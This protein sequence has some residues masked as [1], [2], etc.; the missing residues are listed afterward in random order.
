MH[1]LKRNE[2]QTEMLD[3][4]EPAK[5]V[6]S[7]LQ[8]KIQALLDYCQ[9][10]DWS[11]YDPYDGLNSRIFQAT[12]LRKSAFARLALIQFIKRCPLNLRGLIGVPKTKNAKGIA[13]FA[14]SAIKLEK[15][16]LVEP[17][18]GRDLAEELIDLRSPGHDT[19]C[20]GY[21][22]DWQNRHFMLPK[23]DPNIICST[24]G[25]NALLD[26]FDRYGDQRFLEAATSV[27]DFIRTELNRT[28][29]GDTF[30]FS[31]T[32]HDQ[33]QVHNANL[34]GAAY[35]SR[36]WQHT[37]EEGLREEAIAAAK[38]TIKRQRE[39]G[40]WVYG[41]SPKQGWIDSFHTGYNLL[42]IRQ[43]DQAFD[44]PCLTDSLEAGF[45][46]YL[47]HFFEPGG[48]VKYYNE[49]RYPLDS[50]AIAHAM[51]ALSELS[52]LDPKAL[53]LARQVFDWSSAE[54]RA[55]EGYYY[56]QKKRF[57]TNRIPYIRWTQAWMLIGL[58]SLA[59]AEGS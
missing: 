3:K 11:G 47:D 1:D 44:L 41:E 17:E 42:A 31:Y 43:L 54:M 55:D 14:S 21:P 10:D 15:F 25:G 48:V 30:C 56:F 34:L 38:Y 2:P 13:L 24:F 16:G 27:A 40:S 52:D 51:V 39:D 57:F 37:G 45:H 46:Y 36:V 23:Y 20:W 58:S 18:L 35:L 49:D 4:L 28:I 9:R 26:A 53:G 12:P 8:A 5:A 50:H 19:M 22:F 7:D 33:G 29:D 32:P 6:E 59:E